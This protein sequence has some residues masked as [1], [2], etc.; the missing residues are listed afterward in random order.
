[1]ADA[2][3]LTEITI[4]RYLCR[5]IHTSG[6]RCGSP[7][8]RGEQF[9]YYHHTTR[10]PAPRH[11]GVHPNQTEFELPPVQDRPGI[12]FALAQVLALIASNQLDH[13]R[14]WDLLFGLQVA[15]R[16]LPRELSIAPASRGSRHAVRSYSE[17]DS[18]STSNTNDSNILV[19]DIILDSDLGPIAPIAEAHTPKDQ[20]S[21]FAEMLDDLIHPAPDSNPDPAASALS[22]ADR[23][24]AGQA[25]VSGERSMLAGMERGV[26]ETDSHQPSADSPPQGRPVTAC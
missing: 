23:L 11:F 22:V 24:I 15:S 26:E 18:D 16:N 21:L 25:V 10:R 3:E 7:A 1:M 9:C 20:H 19:E 14:A 6:R 5:H 13:K 4:K 17:S 12:Q 8:L 2:S